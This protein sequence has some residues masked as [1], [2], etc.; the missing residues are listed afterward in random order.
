MGYF[1]Q[2]EVN[3]IRNNTFVKDNFFE[4]RVIGTLNDI[5]NSNNLTFLYKVC[6]EGACVPYYS[7]SVS[8]LI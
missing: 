7:R 8:C 6:S 1:N 2:T 5:I 4:Q 3:A